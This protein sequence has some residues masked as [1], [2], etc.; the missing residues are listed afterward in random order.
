[1][2]HATQCAEGTLLVWGSSLGPWDSGTRLSPDI[3]L[4]RV[5]CRVSFIVRHTSPLQILGVHVGLGTFLAIFNFFARVLVGG[6]DI[7]ISPS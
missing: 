7:S 4:L 5:A 2:P 1:M 6:E 3:L